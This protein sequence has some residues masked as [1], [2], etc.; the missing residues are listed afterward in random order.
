MPVRLGAT[1]RSKKGRD[2]NVMTVSLPDIR[3]FILAQLPSDSSPV[4]IG[5][6]SLFDLIELRGLPEGFFVKSTH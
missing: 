4:S 5:V 6:R 1:L 2:S 3:D